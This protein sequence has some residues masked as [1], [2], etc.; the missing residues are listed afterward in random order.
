MRVVG[1]ISGSGK[2]LVTVIEQ[3]LDSEKQSG[4]PYEVVAIFSDN[5]KSKAEEIGKQYR[6]PV[7]IRDISAYYSERGVKI[8]D[9]KLR[10]EFDTETVKALSPYKA[11]VALYAGYV[12][13]TTAPLVN[14]YIGINV[15]PADLSIEK[16]GK[17][18][19]SGAYGVKDAFTAGEKTVA[20]TAHLV[21]TL[22][23]GGPILMISRSIPVDWGKKS[24]E[25]LE[26]ECLNLL[27]QEARKLFPKVV[28]ALA[29]GNFQRD[30]N[31]LIYYRNIPIPKGYRENS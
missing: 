20:S 30:E 9:K 3:Q 1:L 10:E 2:S 16:D 15:H 24:F 31:G 13:A 25:E 7:V 26:K 17:R 19:Y 23:D 4:S 27:N 5:P 12:W 28:M 8:T 6:I 22:V 29:E 21:T 18:A 11:H 14:A